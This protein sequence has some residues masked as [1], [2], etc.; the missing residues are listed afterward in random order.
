[1]RRKG[2]IRAAALLLC[3]CLGLGL[4]SACKKREVQERVA[5]VVG[6]SGLDGTFSPFAGDSSDADVVSMTQQSLLTTDRNGLVV[7]KAIEGET[8]AYAGTEYTYTGI[9]DLDVD[10]DSAYNETT[11]TWTLRKGVR[12][13]DGEKMTADDIIF[14]YYVLMDPGYKGEKTLYTLPIPGLKSYRTQ[15][16]PE[17]YEKYRLLA[18]DIYVSGR[19]AADDEMERW[20]WDV[21][22]EQAW[23]QQCR[24]IVD[25]CTEHYLD[26]SAEII[27]RSPEEVLKNENLQVLLAMVVWGLAVPEGQVAKG[28]VSGESWRA[29][30]SGI[31]RFVQETML[32]Y[33]GDAEAFFAVESTGEEAMSVLA[34]AN[35]AFIARWGPEDPAQNGA[36]VKAIEGIKKLSDNSVSV[37]LLGAPDAMAIYQLGIPVAPLHHYG[38]AEEYDYEAGKYGFSFGDLTAV[39]SRGAIPMGAGPYRFDRYENGTVY[40]EGNS[41]YWRG[42]PLTHYVE[43]RELEEA[44]LLS[45]LEKGAV[46]IVSPVFSQEAESALQQMNPE[47]AVSGSTAAVQLVD[48]LSYSYV[49]I[50][51]A[52]VN[53]GGNPSSEASRNLRKG[54]AA[55]LS[56]Y[57]STAVEQAYSQRAKLL[58]LPVSDSCWAAPEV[59]TPAYSTDGEGKALYGPETERDAAYQA[60]REAAIGYLQAAGFSWDGNREI[61]VAAP[62]GA[63]MEYSFSMPQSVGADSGEAVLARLFAAAMEKLGIHINIIHD[64]ALWENLQSGTQELWCASRAVGTEPDLRAMF[65]STNIPG[66]SGG[67]TN[68]SRLESAEM[69]ALLDQILTEKNSTE[70]KLLYEQAMDLVLEWAVEVPFYQPQGCHVFSPQRIN[71]ASLTPDMTTFWG[72]MNDIENLQM[73][74]E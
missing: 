55:M 59:K 64:P 38:D 22:M 73:I 30:D 37:T 34:A 67:G 57:R 50:N 61:F 21:A 9:A 24:S 7:Y 6:S 53:V 40:L 29:E 69:D 71:T 43:I 74:L 5:L 56:V 47:G 20:Y 39:E 10:Y 60:A 27:G 70:Q 1:M 14:S 28:L 51:A 68:I 41:H 36:P 19:A 63:K 13:S 16:S 12:F 25:Y 33:D 49:G 52:T 66:G 4:F 72:W 62:D 2:L 23:T 31:S 44:E 15:T 45:Q 54:L 58:Q 17:I 3:L 42:A 48:L 26:K 8:R 46:D 18:G 65:Y 11:Y 32:A 35:T